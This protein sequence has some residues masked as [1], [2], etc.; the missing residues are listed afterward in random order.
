MAYILAYLHPLTPI[1]ISMNY[2]VPTRIQY[3]FKYF[4]AIFE[5][6][7]ANRMVRIQAI[8]LIRHDTNYS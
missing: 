1:F 5:K 3:R 7:V 6:N 2:P 4:E 8:C